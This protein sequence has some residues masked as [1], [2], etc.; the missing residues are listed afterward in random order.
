MPLT[1][2]KVRDELE[3][4]EPDYV[5]LAALGPDAL[6][7]LL[8][9]VQEA[10]ENISAKAAYL[11]S[12]IASEQSVAVLAEAAKSPIDTVRIAAA[13]GLRNIEPAAASP[14]LDTILGDADVGVRKAA[15]RSTRELGVS[16]ARERVEQVSRED[17]VEALRRLALE[18][19][20][21]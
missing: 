9:L 19:L 12:L 15:L 8:T 17:P 16:L 13:S 11:A 3:A 7:H 20:A 10:H 18:M 2:E 14:I 6:P 21:E 5:R 1:L 4:E